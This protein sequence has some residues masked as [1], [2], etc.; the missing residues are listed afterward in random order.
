MLI[1]NADDYGK[2]RTVSDRIL[3][4][5]KNERITSATAMMFM[6]DSERAAQLA[7]ECGMD[8]GL[9]LNLS[10]RFTGGRRSA[11][12]DECH[13]RVA[14]YLTCGRFFQLIY[15]PF[16]SRD[17]EYTFKSQWDRFTELYHRAPAHIDGHRHKH[18]CLNVLLGRLI[19]EGLRVR[20]NFCFGPEEK[21]LLNRLYRLAVDRHL[22]RKFICTD[23]FFSISPFSDRERIRRIGALSQSF[24]VEL[25]A[26]PESDAELAFLMSHEYPQLLGGIPRGNYSMLP[27]GRAA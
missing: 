23:L 11:R 18:L 21:G 20:P 14:R 13:E 2:T 4:C 17:F 15:N 24:N 16:L 3:L 19:P 25:M 27:A 22:R 12:L 5:Y 7:L 9:H 8:V 10:D 1:I 6:A 26:H